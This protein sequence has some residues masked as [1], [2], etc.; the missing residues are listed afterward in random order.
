MTNN[1]TPY[2][3]TLE[4][5]WRQRIEAE[6]GRPILHSADCEELARDMKERRNCSLGSTTIKRMF[7]F[8]EESTKIRRSTYDVL[9]QYLGYKSVADME[10]DLGDTFQVSSYSAVPEIEVRNLKP[11]TRVQITYDPKR[12]IVMRYLGD[13]RFEV[14]VS[15]GSKLEAED[16]VTLTHITLGFE[17]IVTDVER[18]GMHIGPYHAAKISGLTSIQIL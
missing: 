9:A 8:A 13:Y 4:R 2:E 16:I 10:R 18:A 6:F 12:R 15:E 3:P 11:G 14:E 5:E 17:L 7:G 1:T